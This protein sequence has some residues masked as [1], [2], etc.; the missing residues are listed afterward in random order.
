MVNDMIMNKSNP[1]DKQYVIAHE[2]AHVYLKHEQ[3][4]FNE[5]NKDF[6]QEADDLVRSWGFNPNINYLSNTKMAHRAKER[7]RHDTNDDER[8]AKRRRSKRKSFDLQV[9]L[10]E[11][12]LI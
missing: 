2:L 5:K 8:L 9:R 1:E 3:N 10:P 7:K 11:V 4:P 12:T 6:E